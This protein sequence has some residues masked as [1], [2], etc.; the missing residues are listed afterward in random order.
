MARVKYGGGVADM[1]GKMNGQ[2][3]SRNQYGAY[4]RTKVTPIN[5]A[6]TDQVRVRNSLGQIAKRW[7]STLTQAQR[8]AWNAA[9]KIF[10]VRNIFGD[11]LTLNGIALYQQLNLVIQRRNTSVYVDDPPASLAADAVRSVTFNVAVTGNVITID[12]SPTTLPAGQ[13]LYIFAT[14]TLPPGRS[15]VKNSYRFISSPATS[16]T[17][18]DLEPAWSA[19][20]G[21][22]SSSDVGKKISILVAV[23]NNDSGAVSVGL[24]A[25]A[26]VGA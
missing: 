26:I 10:T 6:S 23:V 3:Y 7:G 8:D 17:T 12:V 5:P 19:K 21:A 9:G 4:Q 16:A 14:P 11:V 20:F 1:R 25:D 2:V 13:F 15:F 22:L 24:R 18:I